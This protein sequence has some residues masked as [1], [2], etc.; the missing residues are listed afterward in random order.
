MRVHLGREWVA[1]PVVAILL[2]AASACGSASTSSSTAPSAAKCQVSIAGGQNSAFPPQGGNG[3]VPVRAN[4]DCTWSA[5]S[6]EAW[7]RLTV[8]QG[9]G[10]GQVRFTV[11]ENNTQNDR[12]GQIA[13]SSGERVTVRQDGE[14]LPPPPPPPAP[15]DPTPPAPPPPPAPPDPPD[16]PVPPIPLPGP[17]IDIDGEISALAGACPNLTFQVE[18]RTAW[19]WSG[20]EFKK[21]K[22]QNLQNGM[23]VE[24]RGM[25]QGDG[26]VAVTKIERD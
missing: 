18:G 26:S 19:T 22:C 17:E 2:G 10:D 15:P 16:P 25:V 13:L 7:I 6:S 9:Q 20:T 5:S 21:V 12:A 4:R 23:D 14:P 8:A 11:G 3:N 1:A 24:V